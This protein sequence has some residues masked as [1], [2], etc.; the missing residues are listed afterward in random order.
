VHAP[1]WAGLV[2]RMR[3]RLVTERM[4]DPEGPQLIQVIDDPMELV[5]AI[6]AHYEKRGFQLLPSEREVMLNL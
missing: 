4:I 2:D 6:F 1:F 3:D 5:A